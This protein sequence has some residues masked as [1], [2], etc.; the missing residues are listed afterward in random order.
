MRGSKPKRRTVTRTFRAAVLLAAAG[1]AGSARSTDLARG[2]EVV[3]SEV[4]YNP[5]DS[6]GPDGLFELV[7]VF[8]RSEGTV[9]ISGWKLKDRDD[10]HTFTVPPRTLLAPGAHLV[11]ARSC[12]AVREAY[13]PGVPCVGDFGFPLGNDGESVRLFDGAG[14]LVDHVT[15][16]DRRPWA[17]EADGEGATL[18]RIDASS[19]VTDFSNFA[20]SAP[21]SPPGAPGTPGRPN[22][23]A[24]VLPARHA[25]VID[26]VLYNPVRD[27]AADPLRHCPEEEYLELTNRGAEPIDLSGWSFERGID[28]AFPE[29]TSIAPGEHLIVFHDRAAF[30]AKYGAVPGALGPF[31]GQLDDGGEELLLVD[32]E[33]RPADHVDYNDAAPWP[34]NPDGLRGSIELAD[35]WSD[36]GRGQAWRESADWKGSPGARNSAAEE[37]D[38]R[39][40]AGPQIDEVRAVPAA[41]PERRE[42]LSAD[43]VEVTARVLD[44][45]GVASAVLEVQ[46]LPAGGYIRK[47]DPRFEAEWTPIPMAYDA[48]RMLYL[49]RVPPQPHRTLVRY[50]V[51]ARDGSAAAVESRSPR[52]LDP[53]PNLAY[54]VYDGVPAYVANHRSAFG[55]PGRRHTGLDVVPV[56]HIV[57]DADDI[58][59]AQYTPL[60]YEPA[61][62]WLVTLVHD[63]HVH[64]HCGLALRSSHRYSWPKRPWKVRFNR[65]NLFDG[66]ANDGTPYPR[67]RRRVH[68]M[69]AQH[70]PGKP[71]GESGVFESLAW[72]LFREAGVLGAATTFVHLRF[73]RSPEEHDQFLGDFFGIFLETQAFD[74]TLLEDS[75]R[76]TDQLSSLY[77]F[78][79]GPVKIHPDCTPSMDDV[80]A[81][82]SGYGRTPTRE[83]FDAN[84]DVDRYLSFRTVVELSDNHDMDSLKNFFY[85]FSSATRRWE[86]APWDLDNTFGADSSG[87]EPLVGRVLPLY[88]TELRNRF[89]FLAQVLYDER[90]MFG[91]IDGWSALI[92]ELA[93]ADMDR[94]DTEPRTACPDWPSTAGGN[95]RK[96]LP[97]TT[98]MRVLKLWI[99]QQAHT[100]EPYYRDLQV[101]ATPENAAPLA[102]WPA[103]TPAVLRSGPFADPDAGDAHARSRWM[104]IERGGDWVYPLWQEETDERLVETAV[105]ADL[106]EPGHEHLFRV[107]HMDSTGRWSLLSEPTAF[108]AGKA[109][110]SPP[111][112]PAGLEAT[113]AG[114]RAVALGWRPQAQDPESGVFGYLLRRDGLLLT[115]SPVREARFTDFGPAPGST[116]RYDVAAVNGARLESAPSPAIEVGVP[117]LEALGGWLLPPGGLAY[118]YDARPGEARYGAARG[119]AEA[120]SL[121]GSWS[122]AKADDWDG[123]APGRGDGAPGGAEVEALDGAGDDGGPAS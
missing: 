91:T 62:K 5:P 71:R 31:S 121:D 4:S 83:F 110:A 104:V 89:R 113:H 18:E 106:L 78:E 82:T 87:D 118:L 103:A 41:E 111:E 94:W 64:D 30:E 52:P 86:V 69:S 12:S 46:I 43:E 14:A 116:H 95:C 7:E 45:D 20:A 58:E 9:D 67:R 66:V 28:F 23:R 73:V 107:S 102:G 51:R 117:A 57:A 11:I 13:G 109:D 77:K 74:T 53:E 119:A 35:P 90:R 44:P 92:R 98:R 72:K 32:R 47:T 42:L 54:F 80:R 100:V 61:Y 37:I 101:P 55:L 105:P 97:F 99:R 24:G 68:F 115:A 50:R 120:A 81:F 1:A 114:P 27:P 93:G 29:G 63:G 2:R 16:L 75:G 38:A 6:L 59:E 22:S 56:Y 15:F 76:P 79:G 21:A 60:P 34:V 65:G 123:S 85:Y 70:D 33:G 108:V 19:D 10:L 84:L 122:R 48:E 49:A 36:N 3:I 26:E 17:V 25:V 112:P 96:Y 39:G 88:R 40:G 8:N